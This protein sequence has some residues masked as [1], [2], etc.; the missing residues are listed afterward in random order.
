[1]DK[2]PIS[3]IEL[4]QLVNQV[5]DEVN[6]RLERKKKILVIGSLKDE[7]KALLAASYEVVQETQNQD[8]EL[9]LVTQLSVETMSYMTNGIFGNAQATGLLQGLLRGK[10]VYLLEQGLE[11][12]NY[13]EKAAK[14]L[15]RIYQEQENTLKH[16]G[17]SFLQSVMDTFQYTQETPA[18]MQEKTM[19]FTGAHLLRETDLIRARA[20]GYQT[21]ILNNN[22]KITPLAMDYIANHNLIIRR[23]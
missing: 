13:K 21:M 20:M 23:R 17:I 1:M 8:W 5:C 16:I 14:T 18:W 3:Q 12:R 11:Y 4:E 2:S 10:R 15:Y 6:H 22:T 7:E 9:A 19:D